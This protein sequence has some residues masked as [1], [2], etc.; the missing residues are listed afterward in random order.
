MRP[1]PPRS[2]R[3]ATL[4]P[5]PTLFRSM[6]WLVET[7]SPARAARAVGMS[8]EGAYALRRRPD[9]ASFAIA[10]DA[11]LAQGKARSSGP[12]LY[13]RGIKGVMVPYFYGGL[14]RGERRRHDDAAL[15]K[16]LRIATR[17]AERA[18]RGRG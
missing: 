16:L 2:T 4:F 15:G 8:K 11:A 1:R 12:S 5:Y 9:A 17:N 7:R 6:E 3:T 13:E 10:W 14:Q 18:G